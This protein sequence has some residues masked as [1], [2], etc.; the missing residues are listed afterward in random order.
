MSSEVELTG[1]AVA[2]GAYCRLVQRRL[3]AFVSP[4]LARR[5]GPNMVTTLDLVVGLAA[6][7]CVVTNQLLAGAV[8]VQV[9]GVLSCVDGEVARIRGETSPAGDFY[10]TMT[11]RIVEVAVVAAVITGLAGEFGTGALWAGLLTLAGVLLLVVSS[12]KFRAANRISYPKGRWEK[13]FTWVS[14][15]SDARL[16][17]LTVALVVWAAYGPALALAFLWALAGLIGLN[18][19][20]RAFVLARKLPRVSGTGGSS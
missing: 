14:A 10:D 9:F 19:V 8:L 12:E 17:T 1:K 11:D 20:W 2:D 7:A 5:F 16:L 13:P 18:L 3:S 6:A 4:V 15:G